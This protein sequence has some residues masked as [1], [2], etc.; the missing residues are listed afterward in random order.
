MPL[1]DDRGFG[2]QRREALG[3]ASLIVGLALF[4]IGFLPLSCPAGGPGSP[5]T[6]VPLT[7]N[8]PSLNCTRPAIPLALV[9]WLPGAALA[10][11]GLVVYRR[12]RTRRFL[13]RVPPRAA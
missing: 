13:P 2:M 9:F 4:G 10:A 6:G 3:V 1:R 12:A 5:V 8:G 11:L 7:F